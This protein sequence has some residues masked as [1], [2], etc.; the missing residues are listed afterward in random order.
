[1]AVLQSSIAVAAPVQLTVEH[2]T[3]GDTVQYTP[4]LRSGGF[5][6][7]TRKKR[8]QESS[9]R[10]F[11]QTTSGVSVEGGLSE[12]SFTTLRDHFG[13]LQSHLT[14][15]LALYNTA[16]QKTSLWVSLS[17]NRASALQKNSY[18]AIGN[19]VIRSVTVQSPSD[20]SLEFGSDWNVNLG[21]H[22]RIHAQFSLGSTDTY[23]AG[24]N[25]DLARGNCDYQFE[26]GQSG[27]SVELSDPC[28]DMTALSRIYPNDATV[29]QEFG[30]SPAND[31]RNRA[32]FTR[33]GIGV[34]KSFSTWSVGANYYYQQYFRDKLDNSI[35]S[36][37]N[38]TYKYNQV[39]SL[40]ARRQ[41][42]RQITLGAQADYHRH[43]YL[44]EVP[45]LYT[46]LTSDRFED[47]AVFFSINMT[48]NLIR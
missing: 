32:V 27:G 39:L 37:G 46:R 3:V 10:F 22:S 5:A 29:N 31:L 48:Y 11:W 43:R 4:N 19:Q 14:L 42:T 2:K 21:P 18:T 36:S 26:F 6:S 17:S 41:L 47:D 12:R 9:L 23:N 13:F 15:R 28:G 20:Y 35:E 45:V 7:P 38:N 33:V 24:L 1:M 44:D 8:F 30:V 40:T 34:S 16:E 25:G